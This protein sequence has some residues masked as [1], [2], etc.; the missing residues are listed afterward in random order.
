MKIKKINKTKDVSEY[1][2]STKKLNAPFKKKKL[3]A[4][5]GERKFYSLFPRKLLK[6]KKQIK[7][8]KRTHQG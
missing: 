8:I 2:I 7:N 3:N 5:I 6:N 1:L 4:E